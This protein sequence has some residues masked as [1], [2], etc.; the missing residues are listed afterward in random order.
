M[1]PVTACLYCSNSPSSSSLPLLP[2]PELIITF[3]AT[4][5]ALQRDKIDH[6]KTPWANLHLPL[7]H[8]PPKPEGNVS[9]PQR[10]RSVQVDTPDVGPCWTLDLSGTK[11]KRSDSRQ[12]LSWIRNPEER[13]LSCA[14]HICLRGRTCVL[15]CAARSAL[16]YGPPAAAP[17]VCSRVSGGCTLREV[18][19]QR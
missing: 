3:S 14:A 19:S 1:T 17:G 6:R 5:R 2:P 13:G 7:T 9:H 11:S 10:R 4:G 18:P 8:A 16:G 15:T 12:M